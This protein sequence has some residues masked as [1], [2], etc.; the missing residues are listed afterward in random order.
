MTVANSL[1]YGGNGK[2]YVDDFA[3]KDLSGMHCGGT[4]IARKNDIAKRLL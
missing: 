4:E 3:R 2:R 1:E